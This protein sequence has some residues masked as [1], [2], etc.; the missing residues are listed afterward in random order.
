MAFD[1]VAP[2]IWAAAPPEVHSTL[3]TAGATAAGIT[4]AATS[5]TH[6]SAEYIAALAELEGILAT[7]Q[8]NY[9]GAAAERFVS[10]HQPM[11]LWLADVAA[12]ADFAAGAHAEIAAAYDGAVVMMPTLGE[13]FENHFVHGVLISTNFF[14]VNTIPIGLNEADYQ[15]MWQLAADV[16][17]GWDAVSSAAADSIPPTPV[18]PL[19][20]IPGVGEA[21]SAAATAAGNAT[22]VQAHA[23]G[24]ALSGAEMM[25][26]TLLVRKAGTSPLSITDRLPNPV[27][28][29]SNGS[30]PH[31]S[32]LQGQQALKPESMAGNLLQQAGS[33]GPSA[34]QSVTQGP[35]QLL[36]SAPQQLASAPQQLGSMLTQFAGS[37]AGPNLGQSPMPVG[38][39]GTGAIRGFNPAGLTSLAGG[40]LGTGPTRPLMPSTWGAA[41]TTA[42]ESLTSNARGLTPMVTGLPGGSAASGSS[43][44]GGMMAAGAHNTGGR[45]RRVTTYADDADRKGAYT[46]SR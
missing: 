23:G 14:G 17:T 3:L 46:M 38:F 24:A 8:A 44:G 5:W 15:R 39:A 19:T 2:P 35:G 16:M 33:L 11:L 10:A 43:A 34:A 32:A 29:T 6:L 4:A 37:G 26:N 20:L 36:T 13:L 40:A 1:V 18:S 45:S 21:G 41:P 27:A 12:K 28:E 9:Q 22:L 30:N 31:D 7:I 25:S 42:A